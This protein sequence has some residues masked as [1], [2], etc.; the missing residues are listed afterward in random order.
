[1][2]RHFSPVPFW[3]QWDGEIDVY[4]R[5]LQ[6]PLS[7][8]FEQH[9]EHRLAVSHLL[10][11][12]DLR[13]FGGRN[14]SL[15]IE[16]LVLAGL[17][18]LTMYRVAIHQAELPPYQRKGLAGGVLMVAFSW[19]QSENFTWAFQSQWFAV[20]LFALCA[21]HATNLSA[22]AW[23]SRQGGRSNV[24]LA[25]ALVSATL[26][27]YSM[28]SG[29]LTFP[30]IMLLA[31]YYRLGVARLVAIVTVTALVWFVYFFHWQAPGGSATPAKAL[32]NLAEVLTYFLCY[33]GAPAHHAKFGNAA[34][35]ACGLVMVLVLAWQT[36]RLVF[37]GE[38]G[39]KAA[40]LLAFSIFVTGN[41][42]LTAYGR[43]EGGLSTAF[44]FRYATASLNGWLALLIYTYLNANTTVLRR[45]VLTVAIV[46]LLFLVPIQRHVF[47]D[48][49]QDVYESEVAGLALR[50]HVY[51]AQFTQATFPSVEAVATIAQKAESAQ[52][53]IFSPSQHDFLVPPA[54]ISIGDQCLGSIDQITHTTTPGMLVARG[55]IYAP[56][57]RSVPH[58]IV[59][60]DKAG[61]TI[62]TGVAG[63]IRDDV[64]H[65]YGRRA[66]YA[67]WTAF[68]ASTS[69]IDVVANG[70]IS[71]GSYC[72]IAA[73]KAAPPA[74]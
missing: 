71:K 74:P 15:L 69:G 65:R 11:F 25:A 12:A 21:F 6:H 7:A 9:N 60:T 56:Q 59:L 35:S 27:S 43:Y 52:I 42:L 51:D 40:A 1:V 61:N 3:D 29:L 73:S 8:L 31:W 67:E 45:S 48:D 16:N 38:R 64:R 44:S 39:T 4:L 24:W 26:A 53:S 2:Y 49:V 5:A 36:G 55:W 41:A 19:M 23:Q 18:A 46:V 58:F 66:R 33:L 22:T 13:Y 70:E 68:F 72:D 14:I 20:Y 57:T 32:H 62:G 63:G 28:S 17:L 10:F 50:A 30:V 34:A 54:K 37:T 47:T